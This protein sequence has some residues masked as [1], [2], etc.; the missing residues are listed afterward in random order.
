MRKT[1]YIGNR[2]VYIVI[3]TLIFINFLIY[4]CKK[5]KEPDPEIP[6][7]ETTTVNGAINTNEIGGVGNSVQSAY[8]HNSAVNT[9][10]F[11]VIVAKN[12]TQLL[13]IT[14]QNQHLRGLA[15]SKAGQPITFD[16]L[17]TAQ[18][19]LF[20]TPGITTTN[21]DSTSRRLS[22]LNSQQSFVDFVSFLKSNLNSTPL[23]TLLVQEQGIALM[24]KC[25]MDYAA[26]D[27][28]LK[29]NPDPYFQV[30]QNITSPVE[31]K[32]YNWR[33]VDVYRRDLKID[34][35]EKAVSSIKKPMFGGVPFSWGSIFTLTALNPTIENDNTY[36]SIG[37]DV[38]KSEYYV[39]GIGFQPSSPPPSSII[40]NTGLT[41]CGS[42]FTYLFCPIL[43]LVTG[44]NIGDANDL[45]A[46]ALP[47]IDQLM[48]HGDIQELSAQM[49]NS[50]TLTAL[51]GTTM[52]LLMSSAGY[53]IGEGG[54]TGILVSLKVLTAAQAA[55]LAWL[56]PTIGFAITASNTIIWCKLIFFDTPQFSKYEIPGTTP[57]LLTPASGITVSTLT[58][59]LTCQPVSGAVK[60]RFQVATDP[61]FTSIVVNQEITSSQYQLQSGLLEGNHQYFWRA[62][63]NFSTGEGG[64]SAFWSFSTPVSGQLPEITTSMITEITQN[65]ATCGGNVTSEGNSSVSAKGVCWSTLQSPTISDNQTSNGS[66]PG[67]FTSSLTGL[68]PNTH[69]Y[70]RAY[71]TNSTGTAYGYEKEFT[72]TTSPPSNNILPLAVGNYWTYLPDITPQTVTISITGTITIQGET[73]YKWF[74]QGDQF[75]WYYKNKSDGC[76]AYGY[77]GPYQYPPDLEYK[78]P[79]NPHDTWVTNW[80]AVPVPTTMTCE[81]ISTTFE[82]YSGCYKYHFFLP[83]GKDNFYTK[84]FE[85]ELS[86]KL[87]GLKS[88]ES[89]GY[90][91][92][93]YFVPGLGMVGWENYFQGTRLYKVVLT[94]YH[95]N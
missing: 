92:Y 76:W 83:L 54:S 78:Y 50:E 22:K 30:H 93:Q 33:W 36:P 12:N 32:N 80:I 5:D 4:S 13:F 47:I 11:S 77:S 79:A 95:L 85:N 42:I 75:E 40:H 61:G 28:T 72:T 49:T 44:G 52:N 84:M 6:S 27:T 19:I 46:L 17:S 55:T 1:N 89:V 39:I 9:G 58:P 63:A 23:Q 51:A 43:D 70:V 26:I 14:D 57:I 8:Q 60:Y 56:L 94:D 66:G 88:T 73:C 53:L 15:L 59:V 21:P 29:Y 87:S 91:V 2:N 16:A 3:I 20:L 45:A 86:E 35:T 62:K 71:A 34:G 67:N 48:K 69:Y 38:F 68:N 65:T 41:T 10:N 24:K 7:F 18:G 64:W 37:A 81:S 74:A 82:S 31:L 25:I 90:D